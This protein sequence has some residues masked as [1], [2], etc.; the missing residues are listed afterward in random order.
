MV[1]EG[2][3]LTSPFF[4]DGPVV[5]SRRRRLF[6]RFVERFVTRLQS[7][8]TKYKFKLRRADTR[9]FTNIFFESNDHLR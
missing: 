9:T 1:Q 3:I 7:L 6:S 4:G 2:F 8:R 5:E